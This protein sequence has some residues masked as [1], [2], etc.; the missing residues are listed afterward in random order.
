MARKIS[1]KDLFEQEDLFKEVRDSADKTIKK[2]GD[3][4]R[5][6][7][8]IAKTSQKAMNSLKLG[9]SKSIKTLMTLVEKANKLNKE[10]IAI[11]KARQTALKD[12]KSVV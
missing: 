10:A 8:K 4:K 2:L 9:D 7:Q 6:I 3:F 11:D 1:S 12:R 5:E